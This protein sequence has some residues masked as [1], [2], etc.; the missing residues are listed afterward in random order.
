MID[1]CLKIREDIRIFLSYPQGL[2]LRIKEGEE[3]KLLTYIAEQGID[4]N[5]IVSVGDVVSNTFINK[6][7]E[8]FAY[9][10]DGKTKRNAKSKS[11]SFNY[12]VINPQGYICMNAVRTIRRVSN[13]GGGI[14]VEGEDDLLAIPF[15]NFLD[16][17]YVLYGQPN[18]GVVIIQPDYSMKER[19][20]LIYSSSYIEYLELKEER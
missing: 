10:F 12:K 14:Y 18:K 13:D 7:I 8:P 17:K 20:K 19:A 15:I 4:L 6:G 1:I 2:L 16:D 11:L 9:V 5:K 3:S